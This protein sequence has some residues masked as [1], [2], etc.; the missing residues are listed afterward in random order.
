MVSDRGVVDLAHLLTGERYRHVARFEQGGGDVYCLENLASRRRYVLKR[1]NVAVKTLAALRESLRWANVLRSHGWPMSEVLAT[2]QYDDE[3]VSIEVAFKGHHPDAITPS[4]VQ[5]ML[6]LPAAVRGRGTPVSQWFSTLYRH[7][8]LDVDSGTRPFHPEALTSHTVGRE[9][10]EA[11]E[12]S[13]R[14]IPASLLVDDVVHGDFS[15]GNVV[16][17]RGELQGVIDWDDARPGDA[18]F[19]LSA[20]E[21]DIAMWGRGVGH[22][23]PQI[24]TRIER[25]SQPEVLRFYR[26]YW[27]AWNLTWAIGTTDESTV[28]DTWRSFRAIY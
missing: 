8:S 17:D 16:I 23:L 21:W 7:F 27:A 18:T 19:D 12:V 5:A 24:T 20:L 10:L 6:G 22:L 26:T 9:V 1:R 3:V 15:P 13:F 14:Q 25:D 2:D 28:I 11:A 4:I